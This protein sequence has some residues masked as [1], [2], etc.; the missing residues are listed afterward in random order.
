MTA[1]ADRDAFLLADGGAQ[2]VGPKQAGLRR[3]HWVATS[4]L[5]TMLTLLLTSPAYQPTHPWLHWVRAFAEAGAVGAM[6]DWY[7]VVALFRRPLGLPIPRSAIIPKNKDRIGESLAN[8]VQ[9]NFLTPKNIVRKL[10]E[11]DTAE[12]LAEWLASPA[13]D[14]QVAE[15]VGSLIPG[16]LNALQD[17]DVR[18]LFDRILT[19]ELL[20][21]DVS[22]IAGKVLAILIEGNRHQALLDRG[23]RAL[24]EWLIANQGL[25][26]AKF[27][28]A[29]RYTPVFLDN[30]IVE[31]FLDGICAVLHEV[32]DSPGHELRLQFDE[33]VRELIER[34]QTSAEYRQ[35]GEAV[36]REFV[37]HLRNENY[38]RQLWAEIRLGVE[39]D[40]AGGDSL[41]REHIAGGLVALG[42][43]LL[44]E[45]ALQQ[46]LNAWW[47]NAVE[48][49]VLRHGN[50]I[51]GLI[52]EVV[53]SWD[54]AEVSGKVEL[55]IGKD[56]QFIRING[57]LVGGIAGV[58]LHTLTYVVA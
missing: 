19:P 13:N 14:A 39:A 29:S 12:A 45:S 48:K 21:L 56:L 42:K 4:L 2:K 8:F 37:E 36:L 15:A 20:K 11:H 6:A 38:Y 34:L 17:E 46:K 27:S 25:I 24:E 43:G 47:L 28:E 53:K 51:S 35:N 44:L 9:E 1:L 22:R 50:Q 26:K 52:K 18:R 41:I 3:M 31:K 40:I 54:A 55:E 23:L 5:G 10:K 58:A 57:T 7:A 30:Y 16:I 32:A 33:A 49:M